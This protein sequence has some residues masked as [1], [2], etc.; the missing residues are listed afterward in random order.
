MIY[1][2]SVGSKDRVKKEE[3]KGTFIDIY[4]ICTLLAITSLALTSTNKIHLT[5]P[6]I[7]LYPCG[8]A[9]LWPFESTRLL[10]NVGL[11]C[12]P[13]PRCAVLPCADV[14]EEIIHCI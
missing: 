10:A 2:I 12:S 8:R 6:Y 7:L 3:L 13:C 5:R 14:P 11:N 9:F 4:F 1:N